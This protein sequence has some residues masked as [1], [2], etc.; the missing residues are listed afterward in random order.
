MVSPWMVNV[1]A[2]ALNV[3]MGE[4]SYTCGTFK[5]AI[6]FWR[7]IFK[8]AIK[9]SGVRSLGMN[10]SAPASSAAISLSGSPWEV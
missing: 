3:V 5:C 4:S 1:R 8:W 7:K 10:S 9:T 6:I 2:I